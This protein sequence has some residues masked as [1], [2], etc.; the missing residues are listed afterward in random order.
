M[1][2]LVLIVEA[3]PVVKGGPGLPCPASGVV[4]PTYP[5]V[6]SAGDPAAPGLD[7]EAIPP[8]QPAVAD[9]DDSP[10]SASTRSDDSVYNV[11]DID[12]THVGGM[13]T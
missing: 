10:V 9:T 11:L 13:R 5:T 1:I 12:P 7:V 4:S 6:L 2:V 3:P 8:A